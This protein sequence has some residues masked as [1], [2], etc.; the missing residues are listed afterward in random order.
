MRS[1]LGYKKSPCFLGYFERS[2]WKIR[3]TGFCKTGKKIS[4]RIDGKKNFPQIYFLMSFEPLILYVSSLMWK[5]DVLKSFNVI[6]P[7]LTFKVIMS[8]ALS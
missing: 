3:N 1:F 8:L 7:P 4:R 5:V 2:K 6:E